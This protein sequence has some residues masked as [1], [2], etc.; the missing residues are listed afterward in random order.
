MSF[1]DL[2]S[3]ILHRGNTDTTTVLPEDDSES[4]YEVNNILDSRYDKKNGI[5]YYL[6]DW[7]DF[8]DTKTWEPEENCVNCQDKIK[9][10]RIKLFKKTLLKAMNQV[11]SAVNETSPGLVDS[12]RIELHVENALPHMKTISL[13]KQ[14]Y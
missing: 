8:P 7:V 1:K 11:M 14:V 12:V 2:F 13:N 10:F 6:V 3:T 5:R 4:T 9:E